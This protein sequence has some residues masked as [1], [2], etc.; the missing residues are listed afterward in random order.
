MADQSPPTMPAEDMERAQH[1][2]MRLRMLTG[3]WGPDLERALEAHIPAARRATWGQ[4]NRSRNPYRTLCSQ[5]GGA[6]YHSPPQLR[7]DAG[8]IEALDAAGYWQHMLT[9]STY[10]VGLRELFIRQDVVD[11]RIIAR[12]VDPSLLVLRGSAAEPDVPLYVAE[13]QVRTRRGERTWCWEEIDIRDPQRPS[14]RVLSPDKREDWTAELLPGITEYQYQDDEGVFLPGVLYHAERTGQMWDA[15]Y[16]SEVVYGSLDAAVLSTFWMHGFKSAS[17]S[18]VLLMNGTLPGAEE[19]GERRT[20]YVEPGSFIECSSS[21]EGV[22]PQALQLQ[23]GFDALKAIE[24]IGSFVAAFA[25][26]AGVS[27]ADILRTGGDARSGLSL[28]ISRDGLRQ[29]QARHA[30]QLRRGDLA[31]VRLASRLLNRATGTRHATTGY[32]IEY[33]SLPMSSDELRARREELEAMQRMGL[34][35]PVDAYLRLH[36][37]VTRDQAI[38]ELQRIRQES[39]LYGSTPTAPRI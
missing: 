17:F 9:Q 20:I 18:T 24:A 33:P 21:E 38:A 6:L 4:G 28:A 36:P 12:P 7:G 10:L 31:A 16:G 25:A 15:W 11:G 35:S 26:Y 3:R 27:E 32:A 13:A 37:G 14:H 2:A 30:P 19:D 1:Q 23:A 34:L 39:V 29:A 5:V 22:Q 8:P